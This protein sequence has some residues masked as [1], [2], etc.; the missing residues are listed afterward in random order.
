ME[1]AFLRHLPLSTLSSHYSVFFFLILICVILIHDYGC[2]GIYGFLH[3]R[4]YKDNARLTSSAAEDH[5]KRML[6]NI[7]HVKTDWLGIRAETKYVHN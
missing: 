6:T 5:G 3:I 4:N 7:I 1:M 2:V